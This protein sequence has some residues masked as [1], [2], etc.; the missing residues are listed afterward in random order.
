M[1]EFFE[2]ET[3]I[4]KKQHGFVKR[5]ACVANLLETLDLITKS[6]SEG[7]QFIS[8]ILFFKSIRYDP[9][10]NTDSV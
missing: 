10:S 1:S 7:S 2:K 9:A 8:F 4:G 3:L 5:K 6:L